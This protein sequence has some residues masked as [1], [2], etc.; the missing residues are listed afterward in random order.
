[1]VFFGTILYT[2]SGNNKEKEEHRGSDSKTHM[3]SN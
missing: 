1:M 2:T 3:K